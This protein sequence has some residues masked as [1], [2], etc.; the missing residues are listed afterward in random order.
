M[1]EQIIN[2]EVKNE[3]VKK[4]NIEIEKKNIKKKYNN[5]RWILKK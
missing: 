5:L 3:D 1:D 2:Q 4:I